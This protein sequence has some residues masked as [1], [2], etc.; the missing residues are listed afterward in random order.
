MK[1]TILALLFLG[2]GAA[3][4]AQ[5]RQTTNAGTTGNTTGNN[6]DAMKISNASNNMS[7]GT[8]NAYG[9]P[10]AQLPPSIQ[11]SFQ[12]SYPM[13]TD[14]TWQQ[15]DD[16]WR[17][18]YKNNGQDMNMYYNMA[19]QSYMVALPVLQNQVPDAV[20]SSAKSRFGHQVYDI[21]AMKGTNNQQYYQVR[22]L[23]NG[24]VRTEKIQEDG[25]AYTETMTGNWNNAASGN[26]NNNNMGTGNMG[27]NQ[28]MN[29]AQGANLQNTQSGTSGSTDL[30]GSGQAATGTAISADSNTQ[31][32]NDMNAGG[33]TRPAKDAK[34][35]S[36]NNKSVKK[37][38]Q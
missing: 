30:Q 4:C 37:N 32:A 11:F 31:T 21:T 25:T 9:T 33:S 34:K 29:S 22:V 2:S 1:K 26:M 13:A 14:A 6:A 12:N 19:G 20:A 16:W 17:V 8:Y 10:S 15:A 18:Y 36:H 28:N 7:T 38:N 23:E 24:Q 3:L 27:T 35:G 5:E